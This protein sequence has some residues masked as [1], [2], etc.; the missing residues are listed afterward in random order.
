[1]DN[2]ERGELS[3]NIRSINHSMPRNYVERGVSRYDLKR[4]QPSSSIR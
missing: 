4:K 1:M 2:T 3:R